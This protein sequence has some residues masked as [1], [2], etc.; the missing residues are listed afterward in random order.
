MFLLHTMTVQ[1]SKIASFFLPYSHF[2]GVKCCCFVVSLKYTQCMLELVLCCTN[3]NNI[4]LQ[5]QKEQMSDTINQSLLK[6]TEL[7]PL[8]KF[9]SVFSL[10]IRHL[11]S[12]Q[13]IILSSLFYKFPHFGVSQRR[14]IQQMTQHLSGQGGSTRSSRCVYHLYSV[15]L[16]KVK[17]FSPQCQVNKRGRHQRGHEDKN[18][19]DG[20]RIQPITSEKKTNKKKTPKSTDLQE[21]NKSQIARQKDIAIISGQDLKL[22]LCELGGNLKG[23]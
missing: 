5:Q 11:Q 19:T 6:Q 7:Y 1:C 22:H 20:K 10:K 14:C 8:Y 3:R 9:T 17:S 13:H 15:L 12:L 4:R 16:G 23:F 21:C 18:R 2:Q